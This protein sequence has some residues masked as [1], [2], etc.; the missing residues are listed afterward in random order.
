IPRGVAALGYTQ[1]LEKDERYLMQQGELQDRLAVLLGG[2]A[3]EQLIFGEISSGAGNDLERATDIARRMVT[4]FGMSEE[5]GPVTYGKSRR[6]PFLTVPD[7]MGGGGREYSEATAETIDR[8]V[9]RIIG[10][11]YE[12]A[13]KT[14]RGDRDNL[15]ELALR[16]LD[17]EVVGRDELRALMGTPRVQPGEARRAEVGHAP[18]HAGE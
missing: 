16:L 10:E 2:R 8:E 17:Q 11:A 1:T 15:K 14:L 5:L 18:S 9:R 6:S 12:Q 3:A 13:V 7:E 4:E